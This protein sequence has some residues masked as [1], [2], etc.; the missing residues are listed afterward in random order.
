MAT[1][2]MVKITAVMAAMKSAV[3]LQQ[4]QPFKPQQRH[5]AQLDGYV[6]LTA[7]LKSASNMRGCVMEFLTVQ[8]VGTKNQRTAQLQQRNPLLVHTLS[9]SVH[10]VAVFQKV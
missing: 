9:I 8:I 4:I 3:L 2:A 7:N 5:I 1:D 10:M 6:V